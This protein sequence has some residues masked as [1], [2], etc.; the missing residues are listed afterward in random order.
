MKHLL[1]VF[2]ALWLALNLAAATIYSTTS[3]G[4]WNES[5]TW[6]GGVVPT[7]SDDVIL[8]GPVT[9]NSSSN[10]SHCNDL[11]IQSNGKLTNIIYNS[12]ALQVHGTLTNN[13]EIER[14]GNSGS[15]I[16]HVYGD[17]SNSGIM[18]PQELYLQG[19]AG[20]HLT[21]TGTFHPAL[22]KGTS[23][24]SALYLHSDVNIPGTSTV[25]M[26]NGKIY[27]NHSVTRNFSIV[28]GTVRNL[29]F[30]GGNGATFS[31]SAGTQVTNITA[32]ELELDGHLEFTGTSSFG[33][34]TNRGT[35]DSVTYIT[36]TINIS[37]TLFNYGTITQGFSAT[38]RLFL[39]GDF[40]NHG[41]TDAKIINL[42]EPGPHQL[43]QS[44]SDYQISNSTFTALTGSGNI[45]LLSDLVFKNSTVDFKNNNLI[46]NHNG[47]DYGMTF[48]AGTLSNAIISGN[49]ENYLKGVANENE[50]HTIMNNLQ[51]NNLEIQ[52][53]IHFYGN[54]SVSGTL[55]NNGT[56]STPSYLTNSFT[57]GTKLENH[58]SITQG[59][60]ANTNL[61]LGGDF[62]DHGSIDAKQIYLT[63]PG[64]HQLY[65][66]GS[67]YQLSD[68]S[69][70]ASPGSGNVVLLSDLKFKKATVNFNN[71][72]LV[73]NHGGVDRGVTF[74]GGSFRN[75]EI[76]GNGANFIKGVA[77]ENENNMKMYDF[78]AT[79]LEI[80]GEIHF[81]GNNNVTGTLV[82]NGTMSTPSYL[83]N[84]FT[85]GT[86]LENHGS[87][88]QGPSATTNLSL[89]RHFHNNGS[90]NAKNIKLIAPGPH[91][92]YQSISA[93][94]IKNSNFTADAGSGN[95]ELLSNLS[96]KDSVIDLKNNNLFMYYNGIDRSI[97]L[98]GGNFQNA[99]ISG[100]GANYING[101]LNDSDNPPV[102][103]TFQANNIGFDGTV[104]LHGNN[105]ISGTLTNNGNISTPTYY[106]V[107]VTVGS[108][109]KNYGTISYGA[110]AT[111]ILN[112][113]GDLYNYNSIDSRYL[114]I[115]GTQDQYI[116]N[117]GTINWSGR[118]YL[119]S[120]IGASQ[121]WFNGVVQ[122]N[123]YTLNYNADPTILGTWRPYNGTVFGRQ[124]IIGDGTNLVTPQILSF[125][126]NAGTIELVWAQVPEAMAYTIW[127]SDTPDGVYTQYIQYIIDH[128]LSDGM[129]TQ[130]L[131][132]NVRAR[133][134]R[135]TAIN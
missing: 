8:A 68:S 62:Y 72:T 4:S 92:L 108:M 21:S 115:N 127:A 28:G 123:S 94:P 83:T 48:M 113:A 34:L 56:M 119:V 80:Q 10:P 39:D 126:E 77:D 1:L 5:S 114:Y 50:T 61:S 95:I 58:G 96:F 22:L 23:Q 104:H 13:G 120:E 6:V 106:T 14:T 15:I 63:A 2:A 91:Q 41:F 11:L 31:G 37:E 134:F 52:G 16:V 73:M 87:I 129:V 122:Q 29:E 66:S 81:S 85:V 99:I 42:T 7:V 76:L 111:L 100:N 59:F 40:Y 64:P 103:Q 79:N 27:L 9:P 55:V 121:W 36:S 97:S 60:S 117:A 26:S 107:S 125:T 90:V 70:T 89:N 135:I 53:E 20:T 78:Q 24:D 19:S 98:I 88:T 17:V 84:S 133:F 35:L 124:I 30:V 32:D 102:I 47:V 116:R 131:T 74:M 82:N 105:T 49:G 43:Y 44:G 67:G 128:N 118:L 69:L 65:Q 75:V 86:K 38:T 25:E 109:L 46:M 45:V 101:I 71:N 132:P 18:K 93:E 112:V 33:T 3:G 110:S 54:N 51:A 12:Q 130:H 57:V